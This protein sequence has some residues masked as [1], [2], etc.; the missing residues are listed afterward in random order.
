MELCYVFFCDV[1][2]FE[3]GCVFSVLVGVVFWSFAPL[4][5]LGGCVRHTSRRVCAAHCVRHTTTVSS[6]AP[7]SLR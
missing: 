1:L 5:P 4:S 6:P 2:W 7:P 3:I